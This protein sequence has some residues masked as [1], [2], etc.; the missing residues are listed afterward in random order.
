MLQEARGWSVTS[1]SKFYVEGILEELDVDGEWYFEPSTFTLYLHGDGKNRRDNSSSGSGGGAGWSAP[2]GEVSIPLLATLVSVASNRSA[3]IL[4]P[5]NKE[6]VHDVSMIGF[7]FTQTRS[8][9][10]SE[11]YEVPSAGDWSV[12]RSGTVFV[13]NARNISLERCKFNQTGGNAVVFSASVTDAAVRDSVFT[14]L[15]DSAIVLLGVADVDV[16]VLPTYPNR[17]VVERNHVFDYGVYGKQVSAF[18]QALSAN[19]TVQNNVFHGG[20]RG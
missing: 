1:K 2:T 4:N 12:V 3:F 18:F 16:G 9:Y 15:G 17:N 10:L 7:E 20:P 13:E 6:R 5:A 8:T 14:R 19:S 11:P